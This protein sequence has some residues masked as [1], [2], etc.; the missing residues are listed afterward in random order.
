[1][2][3][4]YHL[5]IRMLSRIWSHLVS[6]LLSP[7]LPETNL[8]K[9]NIDKKNLQIEYMATENMVTDFLTKPLQGKMFKNFRAWLLGLDPEISES[10]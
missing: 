3:G 6:L 5:K 7:G 8:L 2:V 1:M 10:N 9:D 4:I